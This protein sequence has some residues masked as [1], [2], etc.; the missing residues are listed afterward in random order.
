M[1]N[2]TIIHMDLDTFF[3]SCERLINSKLIGKS[4][5]QTREDSEF[6]ICDL[7]EYLHSQAQSFQTMTLES[8]KSKLRLFL[9]KFSKESFILKLILASSFSTEI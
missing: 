8:T 5:K 3:V 7:A 6:N 2:R 4:I 9:F 1:R